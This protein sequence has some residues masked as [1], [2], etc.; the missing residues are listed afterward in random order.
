[1]NELE[2]VLS[3]RSDAGPTAEVLE[4]PGMNSEAVM[5]L[6]ARERRRG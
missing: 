2:R 3:A 6:G 5:A 4:R 1:M